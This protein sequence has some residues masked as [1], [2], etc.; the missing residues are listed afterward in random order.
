[1]KDKL[2]LRSPFLT[3]FLLLTLL[4]SSAN[5]INNTSEKSNLKAEYTY[6]SAYET[7]T[8]FSNCDANAGSMTAINSDVVI[9]GNSIVIEAIPNGDAVIP[10]GYLNG[11]VLTEGDDLV[12]VNSKMQPNFTITTPGAYRIHSV[13]FTPNTLNPS[14]IEF[15]VTTGFDIFELISNSNGS[16]CASLDASGALFTV[17]EF[18]CEADA[19]S[20]TAVMSQVELSNGTAMLSATAGGNAVIPDG[21][22]QAFVLTQG[23]GLVILDYGFE[24]SFEVTSVGEYTIH[25]LVLDPTTLDVTTIELGVTTGFDV[26]EL[27]IAGGGDICASLDVAGAP[28]KVDEAVCE[29]DAGSMTAVMSQVELSNGT[30]MLSAT[31]DGNAVIPDGFAQAFVLTQGDGLVILDYGFE[32]SFEVTSAGEYTIHSLVLDPTTLDV[33]TIE[34]GVTTGFDVFELLIAG[35]GDICASLDVAGAPIKVDEAVCEADA[36]SMYSEH[37]IACMEG[38]SA[39]IFAMIDDAPMIPQG[40]QQIFVLTRAFSLTILNA[41]QTPE[42]TVNQPGFYRIHSL[43]FDPTTLDLTTVEFGSTTGFDVLSLLIAGGGDICASLDVHGAL[44]LVVPKWIC[45][46]FDN[47][48]LGNPTAMVENYAEDFNSYEAFEASFSRDVLDVR[49]Y[50][51]PTNSIANLDTKMVSK[52]TINYSVIDVSGR[53]MFTGEISEINDENI[54]INMDRLKNGTYFIKFESEYRNFTKAIKVSK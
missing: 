32:P 34:L 43:V 52:E 51:N 28:I 39:S 8:Y 13:V 19:G 7:S 38:G 40:Y 3:L 17:E 27:L 1:M 22:A 16:I 23:D 21:F 20:M 50:P 2:L 35:G 15:G 45:N 29:A 24:P 33:T 41:S 42:F 10:I 37:P 44:N 36:G 46:F 5:A 25:S 11:Y 9:T 18:S 49:I 4:F 47:S 6:A 53:T 14:N 30:A 48:R 12:I 31:A 54:S 26:F